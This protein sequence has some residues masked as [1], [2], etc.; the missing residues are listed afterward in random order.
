D[1]ARAGRDVS[2]RREDQRSAAAVEIAEGRTIEKNFVVQFRRQFRAPP[3]RRFQLAPVSRIKGASDDLALHIA[4]Q[5][6]LLVVVEQIIAVKAIGQR[7]ETAA[8]HAGDDVDFVEEAHFVPL[9]SDDLGT[10]KKLQ[11]AIRKRRSTRAPTREGE[12]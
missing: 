1:E 4:L 11:N 10:P 7:G 8:R 9:R 12:D 6:A 2:G 3:T 5:E